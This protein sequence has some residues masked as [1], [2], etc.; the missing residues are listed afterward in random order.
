MDKLKIKH[1]SY[2]GYEEWQHKEYGSWE[3]HGEAEDHVYSIL[4]REEHGNRKGNYMEV[5]VKE[6]ETLLESIEYHA[7]AHTWDMAKPQDKQCWKGYERRIRKALNEY[8]NP[9]KGR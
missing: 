7:A 3:D 6:A 8:K 1:G 5:T 9:A 4:V 2:S